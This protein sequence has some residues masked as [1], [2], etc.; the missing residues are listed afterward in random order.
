MFFNL[1]KRYQ[2]LDNKNRKETPR[3]EQ[4][5][6][7][8][9]KK[10]YIINRNNN[11]KNDL[12]TTF[13]SYKPSLT[14]EIYDSQKY[15]TKIVDKLKDINRR[16][17]YNQNF[18]KHFYNYDRLKKKYIA[19]ISNNNNMKKKMKNCIYSPK[20][21]KNKNNEESYYSQD[22][23]DNSEPPIFL[24]IAIEH[25]LYLEKKNNE[26]N[27]SN[28][29]NKLT[30]I[31]IF[32]DKIIN[33][34]LDK[35]NYDKLFHSSVALRRIEY[36]LKEKF[37]FI[38]KNYLLKIL[39]IQRFI[40][41]F[42][43]NKIYPKII[44]IQSVLRAYFIRTKLFKSFLNLFKP[45]LKRL[46]EILYL[47]WNKLKTIRK[48]NKI[49]KKYRTFKSPKKALVSIS[50]IEIP[51][52]NEGSKVSN[53]ENIENSY[54]NTIISKNINENYNLKSLNE[55]TSNGILNEKSNENSDENIN[56]NLEEY[57]NENINENTEENL[58]ENINEN[59]EEN[60]NENINENTEENLNENINENTEENSNENLN[61][62]SNK[63]LNQNSNENSEN[64]KESLNESNKNKINEK[65]N[66]NFNEK[67]INND[68]IKENVNEN[69]N[70]KIKNNN[71]K[72]NENLDENINEKMIKNKDKL[73]GNLDE[74]LMIKS[75]KQNSQE[76]L[77]KKSKKIKN[78]HLS[79]NMKRRNILSK[80]SNNY[81]ESSEISKEVNKEETEKFSIK[82]NDFEL[83][84][85]ENNLDLSNFEM[86]NI[87]K[88]LEISNL[89]KQLELSNLEK[90][91][92]SNNINDKN[93]FD[94][95]NIKLKPNNN[96]WHIFSKIIIIKNK[97]IEEEKEEE[98]HLIQKSINSDI[99][100]DTKW[101]LFILFLTNF[102][103]KIIQKQ[104]FMQFFGKNEDKKIGFQL[105]NSY[106]LKH[107]KDN[108]LKVKI[109]N[110]NLHIKNV[111]NLEI[112]KGND[113]KN[114]S[115][116][117][118]SIEDN[119]D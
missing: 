68:K 90:E 101:K 108:S 3:K 32:L 100:D 33:T 96:K 113:Y 81:T 41:Y 49:K 21:I 119:S 67:I 105:R 77:I 44:L 12:K 71:D 17:K 29:K 63:N 102:F 13:I 23:Y 111:V 92:K 60:L 5:K 9:G 99:S 31:P 117:M 72:L 50:I 79:E 45:F 116:E 115:I 87:N 46:F 56:E 52:E 88:N 16:K 30:S 89:E 64:E 109:E 85:L 11:A 106:T 26:Q 28:D 42:I 95:K 54:K 48:L 59:T 84:N 80:L 94:N 58:N 70:E 36:D 93:S 51:K 61:E 1:I 20:T 55:N 22:F 35:I 2:L 10:K 40:R 18:L 118:K 57:L 15:E 25:F 110:N 65:L 39:F 86:S 69:L 19:L 6:N 62:N 75:F 7:T 112:G 24:S 27:D 104:I 53:E 98:K 78:K 4:N 73:N 103:T 83:N 91:L 8:T 74:K 107:I 14:E 37:Y 38:E 43:Y 114:Y 66:E 34:K 76:K 97:N 82:E 47:F